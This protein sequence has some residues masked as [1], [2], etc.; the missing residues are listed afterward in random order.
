LALVFA[1]ACGEG[2]KDLA[3]PDSADFAPPAVTGVESPAPFLVNAVMSRGL[4]EICDNDLDDNKDG[5]TDEA[6]C[7]FAGVAGTPV[8]GDGIVPEV[9]DDNPKC[10]DLGYSIGFKVD[11]SPNGTF[12]F[13]AGN[14]E[15]T[16][17][18]PS[19]PS[20]SVTI[21]SAGNPSATFD[22]TSTLPIDAVFVKGGSV[23]GN[24]YVYDP[25]EDTGDTGL[26][27]PTGQDISH[28]EFCYDYEVDVSKDANT[29]LKRTYEWGI[30]KEFDES[31]VGFP[32]DVI[33]DPDHEYT[34]TVDQTGSTDSDWAVSGTITID[35]HTPF[36]ATIEAVSDVITNDIAADVSCGVGV[37][38]PY[39]LPAGGTLAC[40]YET[41]LPDGTNRTN[42]ATV[43]TS[44]DVGGG[45]ASAAVLFDAN[46][47]IIEVNPTVNVTDDYATIGD[48]GDDLQFGPLS[49]GESVKYTRD[50]A[51]PAD[52]SLYDANG[53][54]TAQFVNTATIDED[55][56]KSDDATVDIT[57]YIPA[58][59]KV[60]KTTTEGA[61]DIGQFP[62]SFQLYD[63][64]ETLIE[65]KTLGT[66]GGD[67]TFDADLEDEGTWKVVEVLPVGWVSTTPLEC[68]FEVAFPGS[69]GRTVTCDFDNVEKSRVDLLKLTNGQ[70][71]TNQQ[72]SFTLYDT[73]GNT[74]ATAGT[75]PALLNFGNV[76]LD[77][78]GTYTVCE[79]PIPASWTVQWA[80]D[81]DGNGVIDAGETLPFVGGEADLMNDGLLQVYD[82]DPNYGQNGAVNDTRCVNFQPAPGEITSFIVDNQWKNWNT[83]TSGNQVQTA[84]KNGGPAEGW[85]LLDDLIPTAVGD[86]PLVN[87]EDGVNILDQRELDGNNRKRASDAAY[88]LAMHLLA[89]KLNL[90]AGAETCPEVVTAVAAGDALLASIG[91]DGTGTYLRPKDAEY[92]TALDLAYTLDE[93]NN[94]NLCQ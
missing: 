68:T 39:D 93:Y 53:V 32:G 26:G 3:S 50:F 82:P 37:D 70:P 36:T 87:C 54:Y 18:A 94:G 17:G 84:S 61:E 13:E 60:I 80:V 85:F 52:E 91:F 35:N 56:T 2:A 28:I 86:M 55:E 58:E 8:S 79:S 16:G 25:N 33:P 89:A 41:G 6:Q 75:P 22:W 34:I 42:D 48:Q 78:S 77:P 88:T 10:A 81:E 62:F 9:W 66:G 76:D 12:T 69:A 65:T 1:W 59:A 63:P 64:S 30:T 45:Q 49:D 40:G 46:T 19:D 92:Q 7:Y 44:G 24:L 4:I 83:C 31:Y 72:W 38:F 71:T 27:T 67:V 23:G 15:L 51:C 74:V 90:A 11:Q 43:E 29:S 47:T 73:D 57:C 20:N 14:G 21:S 5:I